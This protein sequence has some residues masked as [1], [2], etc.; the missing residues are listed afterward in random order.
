[1]SQSTTQRFHQEIRTVDL[2]DIQRK[3]EE[4]SHAFL[5]CQR[6][7]DAALLR[8]RLFPDREGKPCEY[9]PLSTAGFRKVKL[10]STQNQP[11]GES[12]DLR[13]IYR[14]HEQ[15]DAIEILS[16]G[17]RIKQRPRP[18]EDPYSRAEKRDLI[19]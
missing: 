3:Y 1:M 12:P 13:I 7:I 4:D 11:K 14:Y 18:P 5:E 19:F 10:F 16:I 6:M 2:P 17:F 15:D 9:E 8:I